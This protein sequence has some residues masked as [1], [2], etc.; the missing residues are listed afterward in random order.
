[1]T[2]EGGTSAGAVPVD[3]LV[4][5]DEPDVAESTADIFRAEGLV[6]AVAG[7]VGAAM[8]VLAGTEVR[9][10]ILDHQ[11]AGDGE[12][13][14]MGRRVLPPVIVMSGMGRESLTELQAEYGER[15]FACLA[16]PVPPLE[17]IRVVRGAIAGR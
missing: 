1:M 13:L 5:E 7:T 4:V 15:L 16:K 11:I 9:S 12:S 14:L 10:I 3:V 8:E 2:T 6:V 17:L